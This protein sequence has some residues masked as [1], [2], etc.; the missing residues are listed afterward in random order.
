MGVGGHM[1]IFGAIA[2]V[3]GVLA[4]AAMPGI[5]SAHHQ[6]PV[7]YV[8]T[9]ASTAPTVNGVLGAGEWDDAP[10]SFLLFGEISG[11]VR[12]KHDSQYLYVALTVADGVVGTKSIGMYFDDDHDGVKDPGEDAILSFVG[13]GDTGSD[14]Y[15]SSTGDIGGASH[16]ADGSNAPGTTPPGNGTNDVI[17]GGTEVGGQVTFELRHPLCSTDDVHDVCL[18]PG[19]TAGVHFQYQSGG[20]FWGATRGHRALTPATGPI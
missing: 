7:N 17:A 18:R 1:R 12:F 4:A 2:V 19:D 14:F 6:P 5:A 11:S 9:A 8:S 10:S 3:G 15:W 20:P 16:Y 13:P